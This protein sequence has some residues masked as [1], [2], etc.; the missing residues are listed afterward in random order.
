[1]HWDQLSNRKRA[2][3]LIT[4]KNTCVV[5]IDSNSYVLLE[6]LYVLTIGTFTGANSMLHSTTISDLVERRAE[7]KENIPSHVHPHHHSVV[8]T[9]RF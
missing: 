4:W 3:L 8:Q 7:G 5:S 2:L 1:M 9:N 6:T